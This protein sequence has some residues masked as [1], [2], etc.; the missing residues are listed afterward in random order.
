MP[1]IS[2]LNKRLV[3]CQCCI[4]SINDAASCEIFETFILINQN[5]QTIRSTLRNMILFRFFSLSLHFSFSS[6]R[7]VKLWFCFRRITLVIVPEGEFRLTLFMKFH[8]NFMIKKKCRCMFY[9]RENTFKTHGQI[10]SES[11]RTV[12]WKCLRNC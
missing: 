8:R 3:L 2:C 4:Y 5:M 6:H 1:E 11:K 9:K 10:E 12:Q 7:D